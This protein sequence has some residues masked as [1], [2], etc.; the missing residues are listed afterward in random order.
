M[1]WGIRAS[2]NNVMPIN[3][4]TLAHCN[5]EIQLSNKTWSGESTLIIWLS[6]GIFYTKYI[7]ESLEIYS[8]S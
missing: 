1:N 8:V 6:Y 7:L 3:V 5:Y 2:N 4:F